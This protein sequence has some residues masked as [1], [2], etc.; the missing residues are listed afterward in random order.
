MNPTGQSGPKLSSNVHETR[1]TFLGDRASLPMDNKTK[2]KIASKTDH[3]ECVYFR[4]RDN[5]GVHSH[6]I[7][8][9][10]AKNPMLQVPSHLYFL[11]NPSY[12]RPKFYIVGLWNFALFAPVTLTLT[13]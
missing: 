5:N 11:Q 4:S 7:R 13:Q 2:D 8:S 1:P 3:R 9:A 12:C 10:I 6:T